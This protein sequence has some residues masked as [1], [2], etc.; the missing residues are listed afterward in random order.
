[1]PRRLFP[2]SNS[3][4]LREKIHEGLAQ[5]TVDA[6]AEVAERCD[7]ADPQDSLDAI[8]PGVSFVDASVDTR[9]SGAV[10]HEC[11]PRVKTIE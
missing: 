5:V 9:S 10:L 4:D 6:A 1:M 3:A 2:K 7:I 11:K 8:L